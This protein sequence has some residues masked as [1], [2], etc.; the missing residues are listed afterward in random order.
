MGANLGLPAQSKGRGDVGQRDSGVR[1]VTSHQH[2]PWHSTAL[3]A[4]CC[5][6]AERG[7][8]RR[9]TL[10]LCAR[11]AASSGS[12]PQKKKHTMKCGNSCGCLA[13]KVLREGRCVSQRRARLGAGRGQGAS[14]AA[15]LPAVPGR[16]R[17]GHCGK[18]AGEEI[19]PTT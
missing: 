15:A 19:P 16:S 17:D 14:P 7:R 9:A 8:R 10:A 1:V 13:D 4:G 18:S 5:V 11:A 12:W 3:S 2:H 6:R